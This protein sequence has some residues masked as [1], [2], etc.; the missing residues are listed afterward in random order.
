VPISVTSLLLEIRR[1][2]QAKVAEGWAKRRLSWKRRAKGEKRE[3]KKGKKTVAFACGALRMVEGTLP[4]SQ[5]RMQ[6][7]V[8]LLFND[9]AATTGQI[10]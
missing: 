8:S 3:R 10:D 1:K 7:S 2:R 5:T 6:F 9:D 4:A